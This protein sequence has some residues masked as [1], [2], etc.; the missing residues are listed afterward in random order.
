MPTISVAQTLGWKPCEATLIGFECNS[1]RGLI[2]IVTGRVGG[3]ATARRARPNRACG[4]F[5]LALSTVLLSLPLAV[6]GQQAELVRRICF[7][8]TRAGRFV[9]L[10]INRKQKGREAGMR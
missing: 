4:S 9:R 2:L 10:G 7:G 3:R 5:A 6:L 1:G 8:R